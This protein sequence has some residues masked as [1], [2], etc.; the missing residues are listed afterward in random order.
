[1]D[2]AWKRIVAHK[3]GN[4]LKSVDMRPRERDDGSQLPKADTAL[5]RLNSAKGAFADEGSKVDDYP[6]A[7]ISLF[8]CASHFNTASRISGRYS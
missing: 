7:S 1:M 5:H 8:K 6:W 4:L 3:L 2:T